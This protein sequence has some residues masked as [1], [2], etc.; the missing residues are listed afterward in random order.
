MSSY[1]IEGHDGV[2]SGE[3]IQVYRIAATEAQ[4]HANRTGE[5]WY[6]IDDE[7]GERQEFAPEVAVPPSL[8]AIAEAVASA[9]K[10]FVARDANKP[11]VRVY[12]GQAAVACYPTT[13]LVNG[14]EL[15]AVQLEKIGC[16]GGHLTQ[17][18]EALDAAGMA[19][20]G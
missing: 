10:I 1:S 13:I 7:T 17:V 16:K 18:R 2:I 15:P 5:S 20:S 6:V 3:G 11:H 12:F 4:R 8:G 9:G 14:S 19:H